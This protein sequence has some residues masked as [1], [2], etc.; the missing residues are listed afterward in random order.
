MEEKQV[1]QIVV[2]KD[3]SYTI[4]AKEGF[5]GQSCREKTRDLEL[6]LGGEL[7]STKNTKD[8]YGGD[9]NNTDIN[10]KL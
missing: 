4:Q 8:Y 6:L 10:L 1:V 9:D 7:I 5:S 3:G 2:K